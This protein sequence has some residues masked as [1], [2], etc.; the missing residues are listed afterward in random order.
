MTATI[1]GVMTAV[2][3]ALAI[4]IIIFVA[5]FFTESPTFL[6]YGCIIDS[7]L[8]LPPPFCR[9]RALSPTP[10]GWAAGSSLFHIVKLHYTQVRAGLLWHVAQRVS[11]LTR[12]VNQFLAVGLL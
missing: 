2:V 8:P 3:A 11:Y 4:A 6:G 7:K 9:S 1:A 5:A 10:P 12:L